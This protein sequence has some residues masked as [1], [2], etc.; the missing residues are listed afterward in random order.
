MFYLFLYLPHTIKMLPETHWENLR[1]ERTPVKREMTQR[2]SPVWLDVSGPV[3]A[4]RHED[5]R[6]RG[7]RPQTRRCCP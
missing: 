7:F 4:L 5:A 1:L 6:H 3:S 2:R